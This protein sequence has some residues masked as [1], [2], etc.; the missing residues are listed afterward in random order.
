MI[1]SRRALGVAML[2][3][4]LAF[5]TPVAAQGLKCTAFMH[6]TDGGWRSLQDDPVIGPSGTIRIR[7]GEILHATDR[8]P[9]G[10]LARALN[11][12]CEGH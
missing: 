1:A 3:L 10:E 7:P 2:P 5:T 9:H 11:D 6:T 12:L 8:D 4:L